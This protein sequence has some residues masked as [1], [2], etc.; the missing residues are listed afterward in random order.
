MGATGGK[1]SKL[2][3]DEDPYD[4]LPGAEG[5]LPDVLKTKKECPD[6]EVGGSPMDVSVVVDMDDK[7]SLGVLYKK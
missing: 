2:D 7:K 1:K 6:D 3:E 4:T 5:S